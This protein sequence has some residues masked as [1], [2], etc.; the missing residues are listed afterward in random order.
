MELGVNMDKTIKAKNQ[1]LEVDVFL[2]HIH[3]VEAINNDVF[4]H[5]ANGV[6]KIK[7]KLYVFDEKYRLEGFIRVNKSFVINIKRV[8]KASHQINSK[9]KLTMID[10]EIIYVTRGFLKEF[11]AYIRGV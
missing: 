7:D 3:Y 9:I 11:K 5:T 8:I 1:D 4:I 6:F 2:N 10:K